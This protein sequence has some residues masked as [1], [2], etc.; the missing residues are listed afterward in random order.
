MQKRGKRYATPRFSASFHV[1]INVQQQQTGFTCSFKKKIP[2]RH[3]EAT[4]CSSSMANGCLQFWIIQS[5]VEMETKAGRL[6]NN[7]RLMTQAGC[8]T[9]LC[10]RSKLMY[11]FL[12]QRVHFAVCIERTIKW[13]SLLRYSHLQPTTSLRLVP[14]RNTT[15]GYQVYATRRRRRRIAVP[16][17]LLT[18][19]LSVS[20]VAMWLATMCVCVHVQ[21]RLLLLLLLYITARQKLESFVR[22]RRERTSGNGG[23]EFWRDEVSAHAHIQTHTHRERERQGI[24]V[25]LPFANCLLREETLGFI[26]SIVC[27]VAD[28]MPRRRPFCLTPLC[29]LPSPSLLLTACVRCVC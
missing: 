22:V 1:I 24:G 25:L 19:L 29:V 3:Q 26:R 9:L 4:S 16:P 5:I 10:I 20:S 21:K 15:S 27:A 17:R 8:S 18:E 11:Q 12:L 13:P 14:H 23:E 7:R 2:S 6:C 28:D